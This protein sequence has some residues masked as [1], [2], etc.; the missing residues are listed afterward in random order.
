MSCWVAY[1]PVRL[2]CRYCSGHMPCS[3]CGPLIRRRIVASKANLH[4]AAR[5]CNAK[6]PPLWCRQLNIMTD[7]TVQDISTLIT[8]WP[9]N[10]AAQ[11]A[12]RLH[13]PT[14]AISGK[15]SRLR[16]EGL[17]PAGGVAKQ[18]DVKPVAGAVTPGVSSDTP[19][20]RTGKAPAGRRRA[21][22][23]AVLHH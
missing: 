12:K 14:G 17:L 6:M 19:E 21:R 23:A 13:R 15:A 8:M 22:Y 2:N 3:G 10:S 9:T 11:I 20:K 5:R 16:H 4:R 7:W 1:A 18:Y